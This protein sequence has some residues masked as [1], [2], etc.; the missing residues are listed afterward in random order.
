MGERRKEIPTLIIQGDADASVN[1]ENA[2]LLSHQW[3]AVNDGKLVKTWII[4]GLGHAWSGGSK[5]GTFTDD[6]TP[7]ATDAIV[8]FFLEAENRKR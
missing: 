2:T 4:P 6:K 3:L 7:R 1:V 8:D 5:E